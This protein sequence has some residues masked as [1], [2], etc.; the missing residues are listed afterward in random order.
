M[1]KYIKAI[2]F[3]KISSEKEWNQILREAEDTFTGY[4]RISLE[5][6]LD[7]CEFRKDFGVDIGICSYGQIDEKETFEREYYVPYFYG[8]GVTSYADIIVE[9]RSDREAYIG[10]CEDAKVGVSLIFHLQNGME[11]MKEF[12]LGRI[13][14]ASTSVTLAGLAVSG[15]ILFPVL[16]SKEQERERKEE[17]RNRMMLLTAAREGNE[18]AIESLTMD[19]IDTYTEVSKRLLSED[20]YSIVD[21]YF[22]PCGVECDQYSILGEILNMDILE[23]RITGEEICVLT[24]DVNELIFDICVPMESITGQPEIGRRFKGDIWLQGYINFP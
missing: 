11:Y 16:K 1:H 12:Q 19:D 2:G 20:V 13:P 7:F 24:L 21:T 9:K 6:N 15:K 4:E 3:Q 17:S 8:S 10:I 5:E 23:N 14:K 18:E 22:M